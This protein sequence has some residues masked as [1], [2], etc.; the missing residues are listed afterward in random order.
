MVPVLHIGAYGF[1]SSGILLATYLIASGT[2]RFLVEFL[3]RNRVLS[4]G[5]KEAQ[6][7]SVA[8][9]LVGAGILVL[10][11]LQIREVRDISGAVVVAGD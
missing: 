1:Y 11:G 10:S 4:L 2:G 5:L 3:S 7:V 6:I 9:T 8:L